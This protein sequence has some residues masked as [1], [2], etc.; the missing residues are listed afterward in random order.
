[1][2]V[3]IGFFGL[4]LPIAFL[5]SRS[6]IVAMGFPINDKFPVGDQLPLR[7]FVKPFARLRG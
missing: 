4:S 5:H 6:S 2:I 3:K 7:A 1:M